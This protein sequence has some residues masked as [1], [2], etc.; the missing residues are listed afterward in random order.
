M[1]DAGCASGSECTNERLFTHGNR[2]VSSDPE[3]V[4]STVGHVKEAILVFLL[5]VKLSHS[6]AGKKK[7]SSKEVT[8]NQT[9]P[10]RA[11]F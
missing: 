6:Q 9:V 2:K 7:Q 4:F 5:F 1:T 3:G 10:K 8:Q 11:N